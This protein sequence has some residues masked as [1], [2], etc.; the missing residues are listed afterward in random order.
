MTLH[1]HAPQITWIVLAIIGLLLQV[2]S[3]GE[4]IKANFWVGLAARAISAG[5]LI[6]GGFFG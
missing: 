4:T 2:A 3:H 1:L 6:W 5:I